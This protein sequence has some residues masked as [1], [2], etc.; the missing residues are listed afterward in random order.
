MYIIC[1]LY[2]YAHENYLIEMKS[3]AYKYAMQK[4]NTITL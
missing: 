1:I 3:Y 4:K 2:K